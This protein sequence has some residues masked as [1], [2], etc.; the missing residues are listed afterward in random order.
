MMKRKIGGVTHEA[1]IEFLER[2]RAPVTIGR[3]A[4]AF[5]TSR[6]AVLVRIATL[7][8]V[9]QRI[10]EDDQGRVYLKKEE[11]AKS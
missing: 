3:I 1:I 6:N 8:F 9:N 2:Q 7:T 4:R 5:G 10:A 11:G